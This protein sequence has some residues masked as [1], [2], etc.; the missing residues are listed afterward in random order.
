MKKG[1]NS[2]IFMTCRGKH[3]IFLLSQISV[4][5][6][7]ACIAQ[8]SFSSSGGTRLSHRAARPGFRTGLSDFPTSLQIFSYLLKLTLFESA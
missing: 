8:V 3:G 6:D 7:G 4:A 5:R 2:L 1:P